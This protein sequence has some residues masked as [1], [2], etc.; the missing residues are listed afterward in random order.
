MIRLLGFPMSPNVR[1]VQIVLEELGT[2]YELEPIDLI[3]GQHKG[4]DY[5]A[6]NP[7]GR[8]PTL[9]DGETTLWE[10]HA[11]AEYLAAKFPAARLGPTTAEEHGHIAKW[12]YMNAAHFGPA[13]AGVFAHTIRLPEEQ[14]IPKIAENG[15]AEATKALGVMDAALS[16]ASFLAAGRLTLADLAFVPSLAFAPMLGFDLATW[17]CVARWLADLKERPSVKKVLG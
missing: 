7:F 5:L 11:I 12:T 1:R 16:A 15:R 8:V 6:K 10:S 4:A 2:P 13:F 17:P 9:I 3:A 14:R